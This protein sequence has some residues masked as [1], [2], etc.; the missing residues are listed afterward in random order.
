MTVQRQVREG[1]LRQGEEER[2]SYTLT[3]TPWGSAPSDAAVK[4]YELA[5]GAWADVSATKLS[6]APSVQG[7]VITCPLVLG[8]TAGNLYRLEIKFVSSGN[9]FEAYAEIEGER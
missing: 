8:L 1:R 7:D 9:T 3:T 6:G 2:I 4:L 5:A